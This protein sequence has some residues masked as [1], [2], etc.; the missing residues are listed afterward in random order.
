MQYFAVHHSYT[1]QLLVLLMAANIDCSDH[2]INE[3]HLRNPRLFLVI[4]IAACLPTSEWG[5]AVNYGR[6][7]LPTESR[8]AITRDQE[9]NKG[10]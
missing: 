9:V 1:T 7:C 5:R 4:I 3:E 2:S 10:V 8:M 6:F